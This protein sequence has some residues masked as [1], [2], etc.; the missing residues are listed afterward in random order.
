VKLNKMKKI[1]AGLVMIIGLAS[2]SLVAFKNVEAYKAECCRD[3]SKCPT[4]SCCE[5]HK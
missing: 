4:K 5:D 3:V 2:V 1:T